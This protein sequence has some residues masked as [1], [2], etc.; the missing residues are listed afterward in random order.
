M[1]MYGCLLAGV[2]DFCVWCTDV[3]LEEV[4]ACIIGFV[5]IKKLPQARK[6]TKEPSLALSNMKANKKA[7]TCHTSVLVSI[8][9]SIIRPCL[10]F[11]TAS[12]RNLQHS[13]AFS[14]LKAP[15]SFSHA[16]ALDGQIRPYGPATTCTHR[17]WLHFQGLAP[18][19]SE[20][21]STRSSRCSVQDSTSPPVSHTG[22]GLHQ[23]DVKC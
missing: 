12:L 14:F 3:L 4:R 20:Q 7:N 9:S 18:P 22:L 13:T 5:N 15:M 21:H 17:C 16:H 6:D 1:W 19:T 2:W 10:T 23:E 8:E 11:Y